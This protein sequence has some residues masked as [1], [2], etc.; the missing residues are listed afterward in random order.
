MTRQAKLLL[1]LLTFWPSA[2]AVLFVGF[3]L[4]MMLGAGRG[5]P[6]GS[7]MVLVFVLHALTMLL[8][9]G[10][11]VYYLIHIVRNPALDNNA[12][13]LWAVVVTMGGFL[14][15]AVYWY[16]NVWQAPDP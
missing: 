8:V 11:L 5:E 2:Y 15:Q 1:G 6:P 10:L 4:A 3:V 13:I 9:M 16:L 12:R 14:G 7:G